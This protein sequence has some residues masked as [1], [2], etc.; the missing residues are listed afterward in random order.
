ML[1]IVVS[2]ALILF[3]A[4]VILLVLIAI[5]LSDPGPV[6]FAHRRVGKGGESFDC[7][8]FRTMCV[9]AEERLAAL[10]SANPALRAEWSS[11]QK[12]IEDPRV[13]PLGH[14]LRN[15]SLDELPQLL[16]VLRGEMSLVG[17]RPIVSAELERYG[18]YA[19]FYLAVRPG[20]TGL[21]QITRDAQTSYRRRVATDV[22]YVRNRSLAFDLKILA[23]TLPAVIAGGGAC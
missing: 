23:A 5:K 6:V 14:F 17:P 8:K 4:P 18:R 9:G 22:F 13:T 3:L 7:L 11:S 21:W 15:T 19:E 12:L 20:L 1:D 2:L 16:N 10:L